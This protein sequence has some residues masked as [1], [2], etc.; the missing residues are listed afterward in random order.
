MVRVGSA[1]RTLRSGDLVGRRVE[2]RALQEWADE[3][4]QGRFRIV[5]VTGDPGVGKTALV[6]AMVPGWRADGVE[7]R[8]GVC[9]EHVAVPYLPVLTAMPSLVPATTASPQAPPP[10]VDRAPELFATV[11]D[12]LLSAARSRRLVLW[13]DDLHWADAATVDLLAHLLTTVT[14]HATLEPLTLLVV[15]GLQAEG[16]PAPTTRVV[17]R[18]AREAAHRELVLGGLDEVSVNELL[19]RSLGARPSR[20]LLADVV[21][22]TEGNALFVGELLAH[23]HRVGALVEEGG[24]IVAHGGVVTGRMALG[25]VLD[26]SVRGLDPQ[27]RIVLEAAA[28]LGNG[29]HIDDVRVVA[30]VDG[31][32]L[33]AA[34]DELESAGM[35]VERTDGTYLL[36]NDELRRIL[37][38]DL[39]TRAGQA[40]HLR[41]AH[42]LLGAGATSDDRALRVAHHLRWAGSKAPPE[43]VLEHVGRAA[44][45]YLGLHAW[46]DAGR[47]VELAIDALER[48]GGRS[49]E[50]LELRLVAALAGFR[51]HDAA[52][53]MRHA[54]RSV[55]LAR[56][57]GDLEGWG[58]AL[59]IAHRS[60][61]TLTDE[62]LADLD[63]RDELLR[64]VEEAGQAVPSV[65][66]RCWQ[67]MSEIAVTAGAPELAQSD[68]AEA[69]R[70]AADLG[71]EVLLAE[72]AFAVGF[73]DLGALRPADAVAS[74]RASA[75][76]ARRGGDEWILA[77]PL[78]RLPLAELML[79][80]LDGAR[81]HAR[82][83][84]AL[85]QR[86]HHWAEQGLARAY[87]A[88][89]ALV[90]NDVGGCELA[91]ADAME[92]HHRSSYPFIVSVAWPVL[93]RSR[94]LRLDR[95][96]ALEVV[97]TWRRS[98]VRGAAR[99][100]LAVDALTSSVD[101]LRRSVDVERLRRGA[102]TAVHGFSAGSLA[103][104]VEL[105]VRLGDAVLLETADGQLLRLHDQGVRFLLPTGAS[106]ERLRGMALAGLGRREE[107]VRMLADAAEDLRASGAETEALHCEV[108]RIV[109]LPAGEDLRD[110]AFDLARRLDAASLLA[111]LERLREHLPASV[112]VGMR[113]RRTVVVWDMVGSTRHLVSVGDEAFAV[114]VDE[115]NALIQQHL[116]RHGG[117]AFK[118]TGD[119]VFAWFRDPA[120][121]L[122]CAQ[123]VR[124]DVTAQFP[125]G[126][127]R[128]VRL[129]AGVAVGEP[130]DRA[131]DL[132]GVAV[133][134][135]ARL[136]DAAGD[137]G[138]LCTAEVVA[139]ARAAA[140]LVR[141]RR[142]ELKG[143]AAPVEVVELGHD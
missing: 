118:Y 108:E 14:R 37:V 75:A 32:E 13:L 127:E 125:D 86:T 68:V 131:G 111:L 114:L 110:D 19:E 17:E 18:L 96:G 26:S 51:N 97:E 107:A 135:A 123:E 2:R 11:T 139:E 94:A 109:A 54:R 71:D 65:R 121:A 4:W 43:L 66:A 5:T 72:V 8:G 24:E 16:S 116:S 115:V 44:R 23:L 80:D 134:T 31:D 6:D 48:V 69:R 90:R 40:L 60:R 113:L 10:L 35:L 84:V 70:L 136:C 85:G 117:V 39:G 1:S 50:E 58:R 112:A 74:F 133:V 67:L 103:V 91:A 22:V 62:L 57:A 89:D 55:E 119:G 61:L 33:D 93:A 36:P 64:F 105:G 49:A 63:A 34:L 59:L 124:R 100:A 129:R 56:D 140:P 102:G 47:C 87:E 99:A 130:V 20:R 15:L 9:H 137:D 77:W 83:A 79:G 78:G 95:L 52:A 122:R 82:D 38:Q 81:E 29:Q 138:V 46:S 76:A 126:S 104:D 28:H 73:T 41:F 45:I 12:E 42:Q 53:A 7:V 30:A 88:L 21:E 92:L 27:A 98:G 142:L 120:A 101:E 3:A 141:P 106:V 128:G 25:D 143:L 132:L